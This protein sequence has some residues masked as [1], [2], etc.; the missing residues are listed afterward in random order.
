MMR[1]ESLVKSILIYKH[2]YIRKVIRMIVYYIYI[3]KCKQRK[4]V[5][6]RLYY[7]KSEISSIP[8]KFSPDFSYCAD[9]TVYFFLF[10]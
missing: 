5:Y 9:L 4:G 10:V 2:I 8:T 3:N 6:V 1:K 7:K